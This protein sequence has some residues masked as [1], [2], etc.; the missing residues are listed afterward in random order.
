[1]N[2]STLKDRPMPDKDVLADVVKDAPISTAKREFSL[3]SGA[4]R[5]GLS[6]N[7]L[8]DACAAGELPYRKNAKNHYVI[9]HDQLI[10]WKKNRD[11]DVE[12]D[13]LETAFVPE[14]NVPKD[15]PLDASSTTSRRT[16]L[17]TSEVGG[18]PSLDEV[19]EN[20]P[21]VKMLLQSQE[22]KSLKTQLQKTESAFDDFRSYAEKTMQVLITD[23]SQAAKIQPDI[24]PKSDE[25]GSS[26]WSRYAAVFMAVALVGVAIY[27]SENIAQQWAKFTADNDS[28]AAAIE[29]PKPQG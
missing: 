25:Q 4:K 13:R 2:D 24:N 18:R 26:F 20:S 21:A 11:E 14:S 16:S 12:R 23:Q 22:I 15:V 19:D 3:T 29:S 17:G 8:R 9:E 7:A 10:Q 27:Y 28:T 6:R 1:M 5:V